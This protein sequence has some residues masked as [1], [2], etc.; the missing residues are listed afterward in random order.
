M[1][2]KKFI[3]ASASL[4]T[5]AIALTLGLASGANAR[6]QY[7]PNGTSTSTTP[8]FNEFYDVP[9]GVGDEAD[10]VRVKPAAGGNADYVNTLNDA[11]TQGSKFTVRT[12][13]HNGADPNFNIGTATAIAHNTV[14]AMNVNSFNVNKKDFVFTSSVSASNAA[15]VTDNATLKCANGVVLKLVPSSVKTYSKTLGFQGA[16]DS[17]VNGTLKIGSRTQGSGD[18]YACWDDRVTI[19]YEVVVEVPEKPVVVKQCTLADPK[20][21]T[22]NKFEITANATVQNTTVQSYTFTVKNA[23]NAVVDT[24]VFNT[25][26]LSQ[27]YNFEQATPGTYTVNAVI[28]TADG[29]ADGECVKTVKV[30]E[31]PKTPAYSCDMF[32]LSFV[33]RK[34]NV[35][36]KPVALNGA[37]FKD[38]TIKYN[39]DDKTKE[40]VTTNA[41]NSEGK[42]VS[43]YTFATDA[44]N[45]EAVA[46]VRFNVPEGNTTVVKDVLCKDAKVLGVKTPP[47]PEKP[48][49]LPATGAGSIVG[50]MALVT[51]AG[52]AMHRQLTLKR[53]R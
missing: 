46:T 15:S 13:V 16:P 12:Y 31:E 40:T 39:A 9:N 37:T 25:T 30:E 24:K 22:R 20:R 2:I 33:D 42:V 11:C 36:F 52:A 14:V 10:F 5:L 48:K 27:T 6:T 50:L 19:T 45:V 53:N 17:S 28:M 35:S 1:S 29:K 49:T 51:V 23:A 21:I 38:A 8:V 34:A 7:N 18:V 47:T 43:S 4:L 44:K 26:A 3:S 41:L 32:T